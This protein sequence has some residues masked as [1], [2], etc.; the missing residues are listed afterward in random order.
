MYRIQSVGRALPNCVL[1]LAAVFAAACGSSQGGKAGPAGRPGT[2]ATEAPPAKLAIAAQFA[3][4]SSFSEG[5]AAVQVGE[6]GTGKWGFIDKSGR[7]VIPAEYRL[8][9][10]FQR[11]PG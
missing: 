6:Q 4:A 7:L 3:R 5:L 1:L 8:G 9:R 2:A 11:R 10:G